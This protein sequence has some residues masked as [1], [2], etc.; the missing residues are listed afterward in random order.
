[1][2]CCSYSPIQFEVVNEDEGYQINSSVNISFADMSIDDKE[3]ERF[4]DVISTDD[5]NLTSSGRLRST[6][7]NSFQYS[8]HIESAF[9]MNFQKSGRGIVSNSCNLKSNENL[10]DC[11]SRFEY[12]PTYQ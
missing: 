7:C 9:L 4:G 12:L 5:I 11:Q 8:N 6:S 1:M 3:N 2:G 10:L